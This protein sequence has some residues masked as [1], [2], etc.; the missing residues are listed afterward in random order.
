MPIEA[1]IAHRIT[2]A[3]PSDSPKVRIATSLWPGDGLHESLFRD[4]KTSVLRRAGKEYGRFSEDR[5]EFPFASWLTQFHSQSI[6]FERLSE[7]FAHQFAH[8]LNTTDC[9]V[10][11][12]LVIGYE[13][14]EQSNQLHFFW[15]EHET[16][17]YLDGDLTVNTSTYLDIE[18]IRLAAKIDLNDWFSDEDYRKA[19]AIALLRW[20]GEKPLS[21]AFVS[22]LGFCEK[23]DLAAE[24][25]T[26]LESVSQYTEALPEEVAKHTHKQVVHYCLEQAAD[27]KPV[28]LAELAQHVHDTLPDPKECPTP[29]A[30]P[31]KF[32]DYVQQHNTKTKP[33]FIP[34]KNRMRNFIRIS[35]RNELLSMSFASSCLGESVIYDP[36]TDSL[37][38]KQLPSSLKSKLKKWVSPTQ[39]SE[40]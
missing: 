11:A 25:D 19:N 15:V 40:T 1:I 12:N 4:M 36:S 30:P 22:A 17:L 29:F 6:G 38:I 26:F 24:T 39:E 34:D 32:D 13:T 35:G 9:V 27:D 16:G 28:V 7:H 33:E 20:R 31:P 10:D 37:T 2:R 5:A 21:D 14:L 18:G 23:L 3:S 8:A